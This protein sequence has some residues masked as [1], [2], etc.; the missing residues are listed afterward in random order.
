[1]GSI[2]GSKKTH[3]TWHVWEVLFQLAGVGDLR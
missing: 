2:D 1:M 3:G